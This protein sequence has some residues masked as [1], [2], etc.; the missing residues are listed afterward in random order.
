MIS[1]K[2]KVMVIL[3]LTPFIPATF[4]VSTFY[5]FYLLYLSAASKGFRLFGAV[6]S[7]RTAQI[8]L[9]TC[10]TQNDVCV[11]SSFGEWGG[12]AFL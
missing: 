4:I 1:L 12:G 3:D 7:L 10:C 2:L 5:K 6:N 11:T 9:P 8:S